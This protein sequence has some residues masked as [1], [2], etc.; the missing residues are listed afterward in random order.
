V[1]ELE[2]G[3]ADG[4]GG[5]GVHVLSLSER[6]SVGGERSSPG[7]LPG[8]GRGR[9]SASGPETAIDRLGSGGIRSG[10]GRSL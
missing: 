5:F 8:R 9:S 3:L 10:L 2:Q 4:G 6:S 1:D 7:L